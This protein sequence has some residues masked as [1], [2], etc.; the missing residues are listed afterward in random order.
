[1]LNWFY[2]DWHNHIQKDWADLVYDIKNI[3][4]YN[5]YCNSKEFYMIFKN[6]IISLLIGKK[7]ILLDS[8]FSLDELNCLI[9]P[10]DLKSQNESLNE[11]H[12]P[13]FNTKE[14]LIGLLRNP[15][16]DWSITLFTSGT[17]GVPKK[18]THTFESITRFVS[19]SE[20]NANNIWG[21]AY[22]PTHM[23]GIQVL[24]QAL[25]NGNSVVRLFELPKDDIFQS[26]K[27]LQITNISATPTFY[28]LLLP[29]YENY[30]TV[31]RITS[32][33]EKFDEKIINQ[34]SKVFPNAKVTN[35]YASTEAGTIFASDGNCFYIK[36]EI[37]QFIK[38]EN[39]ELFI[40]QSLMGLSEMKTE[41]WY[42]T[43]D[44][45]EILSENPVKFKFVSRKNEMI[46]VGGYKVNPNE[47][48]EII[49]NIPGIINARIYSKQ[50]SILGNII[51]C[52]VIKEDKELTEAK[53]RAI[54][55]SKIQEYKIP[56]MIRFVE[57]MTTTRTGKIK[58]N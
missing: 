53:I 5:P 45:I 39:N 11:N 23:A 9:G 3:D 16:K 13:S 18:V 12:I 49:R 51:C 47:V 31:N 7:I 56:R 24:F 43:G 46:N 4:S 36:P 40:H 44:L 27:E 10:I 2:K 35:V 58:R 54:L 50:N 37:D 19:I 30:P 8:D 33:G 55:Q 20:K 29:V 22:N 48:E 32:G 1:M 25:L 52:E 26:I 34:L 14:D 41:E 17:T 57:Q 15:S 42:S 21:F 38:I 28:R 6:I